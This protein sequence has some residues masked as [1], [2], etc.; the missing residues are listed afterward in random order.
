MVSLVFVDK[1]DRNR[2]LEIEFPDFLFR[3]V[4]GWIRNFNLEYLVA[5]GCPLYLW[6]Y[7]VKWKWVLWNHVLNHMLRK[8]SYVFGYP[9]ILLSLNVYKTLARLRRPIFHY[10]WVYVGFNILSELGDF[11]DL[12]RPRRPIFPYPWVSMY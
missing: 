8:G 7:Y 12:A 2:F 11:G 5:R 4:F 6:K 9:Y 10:P 3:C 1:I